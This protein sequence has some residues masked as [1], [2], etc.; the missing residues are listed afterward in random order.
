[1]NFIIYHRNRTQR[2]QE[3]AIAHHTFSILLYRYLTYVVCSVRPFVDVS[4]RRLNKASYVSESVKTV[5]VTERDKLTRLGF[6]LP[7]A[8]TYHLS[9][10]FE[11]C[12]RAVE[13]LMRCEPAMLDT[14]LPLTYV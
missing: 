9:S 14:A 6:R 11:V 13:L 10:S 3:D 8:Y 4:L 12:A 7:S 5:C 1:M 2:T